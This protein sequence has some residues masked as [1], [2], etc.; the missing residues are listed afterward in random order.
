MDERVVVHYCLPRNLPT[1]RHPIPELTLRFT[2]LVFVLPA[3]LGA[4]ILPTLPVA[5]SPAAVE[6]N[7]NSRRAGALSNGIL[8]VNLEARVGELS[9]EGPNNPSLTVYAF[10]EEGKA[11]QAPGPQIRVR[12]G[13]TVHVTLRNLLPKALLVRGLGARPGLDSIDIAP[14]TAKDVTFVPTVPGTYYY[15]GRTEENRVGLGTHDDGQLVGALIVDSAAARQSDRVMIIT[16]AALAAGK[17]KPVNAHFLINGRAWPYTERLTLGVGD[18]AFWH[19]IN[20]SAA[21]HPMHLHGFYYRVDSRGDANRDTVF[22]AGQRRAVVTELMFP[23]STMAMTFAPDRPGNW[24]FHCH[25]IAH[26]SPE[27]RLGDTREIRDEVGHGAANHALEGM[28]GLVMGISVH[29]SMKPAARAVAALPPRK[30]NLFVDERANFFGSDPGF[31]F[32]LQNG[33]VIPPKDSIR[34]PGSPIILTRGVPVEIT[35]SNRTASMATVHW[36]G[37]ELNSFYDGVGDWS[38]W[39]SRTAPPIMPGKSFVVKFTPDRAGTF[40]YH[41]H[42]DESKQLSSGLYGPLIVVEP[43]ETYDEET[44]RVILLAAGGPARDAPPMI[45][46]STDPAAMPLQA[47]HTYRLRLIN[48]TPS[49]MKVV[50][51]LADTVVQSWRAFAKDG[52]YLPP[53]QATMRPARLMLGP[54]ETYDFEFTPAAGKLKLE[55]VT[56]RHL[57]PPVTGFLPM[58]VK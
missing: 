49:D 22:R 48:I 13:T 23:G 38:G 8:T 39:R 40:I 15:W 11:L 56:F 43:H 44:N 32:V 18:S 26:I 42:N 41:T 51:L 1:A 58:E 54:G 50:R 17:G 31:S 16:L 35:V 55:V 5:K 27:Q 46:G 7:D 52:A 37:I 36:H 34:I 45:N 24:L 3:V 20:G 30:L 9:P 57:V 28:A 53:Q 12:V 47:G 6:S 19:V 10:G 21:P 29:P 25:L 33:P 2:S 14:G 4:R